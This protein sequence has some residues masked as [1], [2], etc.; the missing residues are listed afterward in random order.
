MFM[1]PLVLVVEDDRHRADALKAML[2]AS[3]FQVLGPAAT[4]EAALHLINESAP[5]AA[6]LDINLGD[7]NIVTVAAVL[8]AIDVRFLVAT[9]AEIA[10]LGS[11][12]GVISAFKAKK[13]RSGGLLIET[14]AEMLS[15]RRPRLGRLDWAAGPRQH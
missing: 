9:A 15:D 6:V 7:G 10:T 1:A 3:D 12:P 13:Q 2:N 8:D 4:V 11:D 5:D 14:L